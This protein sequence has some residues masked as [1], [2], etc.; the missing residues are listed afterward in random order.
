MRVLRYTAL[1]L[2]AGALVLSAQTSPLSPEQRAQFHG[3]YSQPEEAF[4]LVGNIYYVG[5]KNTAACLITTPQG[6]N[7]IDT[8]TK[9][10]TPAITASLQKLGLNRRD[11]NIMH[12]Q[13]G[14]F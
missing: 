11:I 9:H 2:M 5:G 13:P 8:G 1:L 10:M 7:L 3:P 6:H 12:A 4:R 14:A